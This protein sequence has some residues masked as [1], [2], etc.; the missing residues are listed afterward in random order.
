MCGRRSAR[1]LLSRSSRRRAVGRWRLPHVV[2]GNALPLETRDEFAGNRVEIPE[3]VG[4]R[5]RRRLFHREHLY[6]PTTDLQVVSVAFHR[7]IADEVVEVSVV[8]QRSRVDYGFVVVH[9]LAE[10]PKRLCLRQL[11]EADVVELDLEGVR[12][13]M[14]R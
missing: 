8:P 9:Q 3:E 12:F 11:R 14:Q 6:V 1:S 13:V 5:L 7:R 4:E 10:E 2:A